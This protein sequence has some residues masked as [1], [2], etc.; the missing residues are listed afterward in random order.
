[1]SKFQPFPS[2]NCFA[3]SNW[4]EVLQFYLLE[5]VYQSTEDS[6]L[7]SCVFVCVCVCLCVCVSVCVQI[8]TAVEEGEEYPRH[9]AL[10]VATLFP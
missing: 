2:T 9:P 7:C 4:E 10:S 3:T 8:Q 1:M 5:G 6:A